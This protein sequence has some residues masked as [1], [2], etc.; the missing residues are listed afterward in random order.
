MPTPPLPEQPGRA[1]VPYQRE[2][3]GDWYIRDGSGSEHRLLDL[4]P[5]LERQALKDPEHVA[6]RKGV[7]A[8][9]VAWREYHDRQCANWTP[10]D[11]VLAKGGFMA[12]WEAR[13]DAQYKLTTRSDGT[14]ELDNEF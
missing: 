11:T 13:K 14:E 12:G 8:R 10:R 1:A 7:S 4:A 5:V 9:D 3:D 6:A 2:P